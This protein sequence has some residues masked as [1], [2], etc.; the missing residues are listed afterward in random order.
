MK[1]AVALHG[2]ATVLAVLDDGDTVEVAAAVRAG[3][4]FECLDDQPF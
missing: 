3:M 2:I 4:G 1:P